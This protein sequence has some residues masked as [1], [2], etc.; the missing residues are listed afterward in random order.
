M[1][2]QLVESM[3]TAW[4]PD[5]YTDDYREALKDLIEEKIEH[6]DKA[7]PAPAI[8]RSPPMVDLVAILQKSIQETSRPAKPRRP[9]T[10]SA[11][12]TTVLKRH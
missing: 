4:K 12:S 5:A 10:K 2:L 7:N 1:A 8:K 9:E 3:S 6:G 11:K